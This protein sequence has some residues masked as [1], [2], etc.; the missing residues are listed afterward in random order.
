MR[1]FIHKNEEI[2]LVNI[3]SLIICC[4]LYTVCVYLTYVLQTSWIYLLFFLIFLVNCD[5]R[6]L[7]LTWIM[8]S[9]FFSFNFSFKF[10]QKVNFRLLSWYLVGWIYLIFIF[11]SILLFLFMF[12]CRYIVCYCFSLFLWMICKTFDEKPWWK[13]F[14]TWELGDKKT[15]EK[16]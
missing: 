4:L 12:I 2:L 6:C 13:N 8:S 15:R 10:F 7:L 1:I 5:H 9:V 16:N 11:D 14:N 3:R